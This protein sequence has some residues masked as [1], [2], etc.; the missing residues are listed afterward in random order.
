MYKLAKVS[1]K[2]RSII[3]SNTAANVGLHEAIIEKDFW[4]C[5]MLDYLFHKS[6]WGE[7]FAFKGGTSLSK[8]YHAIKRFSE[9]IDLI[10]DWRLLGYELTEPWNE[11]SRTK[12]SLFNKEANQLTAKLLKMDFLPRMN[13]DLGKLIGCQNCLSIA[14]D[15]D[16]KD[17]EQTVIFRYPKAFTVDSILPE[18]RLEFGAL[19]VWTPLEEKTITPI[20][21]EQYPQIFTQLNTQIRTTA[22]ER[23]FWEKATILHRE[24]NRPEN[25]PMPMRYARHYYDLYCLYNSPYRDT[26]FSSLDLLKQVSEF[27]NKFYYNS[28]AGYSEAWPGTFKLTPSAHNLE[29]LRKDYQDMRAMI[30]G[31]YPAF[32]ELMEAMANIEAEINSL[33]AEK[34][35]RSV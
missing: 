4:V 8:A 27:K 28:W 34:P 29:R 22:V 26:I 17:C 3:I 19:A 11:R 23:A 13:G 16:N 5:F 21:G 20:I 33:L 12:Q 18:I 30:Y 35:L 10:L 9:D 31:K 25:S 24:A 7:H 1:P 6:P 15:I 14:E 2:E 32:E